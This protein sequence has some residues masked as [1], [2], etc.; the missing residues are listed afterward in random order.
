MSFARRASAFRTMA[1]SDLLASDRP[2]NV[3]L[4]NHFYRPHVQL[5]VVKFMF[6]DMDSSLK[7][8]FERNFLNDLKLK[9]EKKVFIKL[10]F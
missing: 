9:Y 10:E 1:D 6:A 7:E 8:K 5:L 3:K 2:W 4:L